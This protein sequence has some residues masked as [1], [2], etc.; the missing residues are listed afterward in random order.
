MRAKRA[1]LDDLLVPDGEAIE[2]GED[3]EIVDVYAPAVPTHMRPEIGLPVHVRL[4]YP[5]PLAAV[6]SWYVLESFTE[7]LDGGVVCLRFAK[8]CDPDTYL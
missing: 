8:L 5:P 3:G 6:E 1:F 4:E 2:L 7:P